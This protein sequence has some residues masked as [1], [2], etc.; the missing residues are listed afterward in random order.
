MPR[1][2]P[3]RE[4]PL[5]CCRERLFPTEEVQDKHDEGNNQDEVNETARDMGE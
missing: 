1:S 5:H 2:R 4:K 3:R